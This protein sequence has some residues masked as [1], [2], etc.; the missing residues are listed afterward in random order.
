MLVVVVALAVVVLLG[1][2]IL[3]GGV[4][5]RPLNTVGDEVGGVVALE[6]ALR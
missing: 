5:F 2:V 6:S 4:K 1:V 3:V